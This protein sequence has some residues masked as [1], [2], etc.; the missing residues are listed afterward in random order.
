[1]SEVTSV[2]WGPFI[3]NLNDNLSTKIYLRIKTNLIYI[4]FRV[5]VSIY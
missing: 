3:I 5:Q 4:I 1:M 2:A